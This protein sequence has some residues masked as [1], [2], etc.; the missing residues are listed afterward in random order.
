[1][2][3]VAPSRRGRWRRSRAVRPVV[4]GV[5][6]ARGAALVEVF[7]A[8]LARLEHLAPA[9]QDAIV[10][11][12]SHGTR[13]GMARWWARSCSEICQRRSEQD[14]RIAS[15]ERRAR[16]VATRSRRARAEPR[17]LGARRAQRCR[18][19]NAHRNRRCATPFEGQAVVGPLPALLISRPFRHR[20]RWSARRSPL[21]RRVKA[22]PPNRR[23]GSRKRRQVDQSEGSAEASRGA[24]AIASKVVPVNYAC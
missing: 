15:N 8:A 23:T 1:M 22:P 5:A 12:P 21:G 11:S 2:A 4:P 7:R 9:E 17:R 16:Q 20:P 3:R 6:S 14:D 19:P 10:S 13:D 24:R 18:R